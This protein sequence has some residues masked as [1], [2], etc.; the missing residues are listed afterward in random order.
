[1]AETSPEVT[2]EKRS[3]LA[4]R[5]VVELRGKLAG[6]GD[7]FD[8]WL[9]ETGHGKPLRKHHSQVARL[10]EQLRCMAAGV[11]QR[12]DELS[13]DDD[14]ILAQCRTVQAKMLEV[15]RIWDYFRSKLNLRYVSWFQPYLATADEFAW[16][17]YEPVQQAA[18]R[19]AA[20]LRGAPLVFLSGSFSP[21]TF[22][23]ETEFPVEYVPETINSAEFQT[24]VRALPIP[25]IGLPWYQ[26]SHLP[27][28]PLIAHEIAH[29]VEEDF[30]LSTTI[31]GHLAPA[32]SGM[33]PG[34][35]HAWETWVSEVW[36]DLYAVLVA[37]PAVVGAMA[38][39]LVTDPV[40]VAVEA[41]A[42]A[43]FAEHPPGSLR[44]RLMTLALTETGFPSHGATYW[45]D[46][47]TSFM[48]GMVHPVFDV[49]PHVV[50]A[51]LT[52]P[53]P[54]LGNRSLPDVLCFSNTQQSTARSVS[55]EA[56]A[57]LAPTSSDIR[58]LV[59]G[60]RLAFDSNPDRFVLETEK[61][62]GARRRI[63]DR[64][65][66]VIGDAPRRSKAEENVTPADDQKAGEALFARLEQLVAGDER[67]KGGRS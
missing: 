53:F 27:D 39:L 62:V 45:D 30:D 33:D 54:Q 11:G 13:L 9:A 34:P 61:V 19:Q 15:H 56:L 63:L 60:A 25:V 29:D 51:M 46:W 21:Y 37:G 7:E 3:E 17:C 10:T 59:A 55:K 48:G 23:R 40:Q 2:P 44:V 50:E 16:R 28:A 24:F 64:A 47:C 52:G 6:I 38:D 41:Q 49:A 32:L 5:K 31:R 66:A 14:E 26:V 67:L 20:S 36:A 58:C 42:P 12:I 8:V 35:R 18:G 43:A 22:T 57:D 65:V 1:M 4:A